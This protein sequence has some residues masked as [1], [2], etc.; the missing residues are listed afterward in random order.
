MKPLFPAHWQ[1]VAVRKDI[2]PLAMDYGRYD[3]LEDA[4]VLHLIICRNESARVVGYFALI[5]SQHLHYKDTLMAMSDFYYL[6]PEARS[7]TNAA[8]LFQFAE[9]SL[10]DRGVKV[11]SCTTKVHS[12]KSAF[13]KFI[14]WQH[15]ENQFT[16]VIA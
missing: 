13:L 14:G 3:A 15:T 16:K 6:I 2:I 4:G 12:D 8:Q 10:K 7:G 5:I 1:E 9:Q 11:V